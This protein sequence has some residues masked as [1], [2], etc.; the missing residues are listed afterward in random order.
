MQA[1]ISQWLTTDHVV[2]STDDVAD[3]DISDGWDDSITTLLNEDHHTPWPRLTAETQLGVGHK[4][5]AI[6]VVT[7][8]QHTALAQVIRQ[9]Q[10][11]PLC[12]CCCCS[13]WLEHKYHTSQTKS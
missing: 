13:Q 11:H 10:L 2:L 5:L 8:H 1:G 9:T 12:C 6:G 4:V 7:Y 3:L